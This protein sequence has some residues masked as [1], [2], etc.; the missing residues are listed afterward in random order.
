[1]ILIGWLGF[2]DGGSS[3]SR[4]SYSLQMQGPGSYLSSVRLLHEVRNQTVEWNNS[5]FWLW[6]YYL[7][8][9]YS[10]GKRDGQDGEPH[11]SW[12]NLPPPHPL[13]RVTFFGKSKNNEKRRL[14][15]LG[16]QRHTHVVRFL[17]FV[18]CKYE[19]STHQHWTIFA[20]FRMA[21]F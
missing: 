8:H 5:W 19:L 20:K 2:R 12:S 1:M 17:E 3:T 4:P 7:R 11:N 15:C 9:D 10:C 6:W 16:L 14:F 21:I 18:G 13:H